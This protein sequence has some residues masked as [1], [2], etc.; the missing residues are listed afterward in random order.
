MHRSPSET[1]IYSKDLQILGSTRT[2]SSVFR[3]L[4]VSDLLRLGSIL[5]WP[6]PGGGEGPGQRASVT[7][8]PPARGH[9]AV[10]HQGDP[11]LVRGWKMGE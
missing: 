2:I 7:G 1:G 3:D 8:L 10:S 9:W 6:A 5:S 4:W 11:A